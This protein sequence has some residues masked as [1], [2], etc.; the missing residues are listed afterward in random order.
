MPIRDLLAMKGG[1]LPKDSVLGGI[2]FSRIPDANVSA[3]ALMRA[4]A[5]EGLDPALLPDSR[6]PVH[7]F[8]L[9]CRSVQSR[10]TDASPT[11]DEVKV[12]EVYEDHA[13]CVY[14]VTRLIRDRGQEV[15][16]HEKA[17]RVIFD[18]T[19]AADP[20]LVEPLER[21]HY[22]ALKG[23]EDRIREFY[24][25]NAGKVPGSK[26]R[27]AVREM[28]KRAHA[29]KLRDS[30]YFVPIEHYEIVESLTSVIEA[31]FDDGSMYA[32]AVPN[33][34]AA[35]KMVEDSHVANVRNDAEQMVA[36]IA[37]RL[38]NSGKPRMDFF[39][40]KVKAR[41]DLTERTERYVSLLGR[42]ASDVKNVLSTLDE[43]MER[44]MES[45]T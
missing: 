31:M 17:M 34:K 22:G 21:S 14:Q 8:Q 42:E 45:V 40:N 7:D 25:Q 27:G 1:M 3:D 26:V 9:A 23:L 32:L 36:E 30:V 12:D 24:A 38:T 44:L 5:S 10:R 37:N 35:Q 19:G 33:T 11:K 15:I 28:F 4:W 39:T 18:K 43:Q 16:D 13:R 41:R 6:R 20:I 2:V 29:E